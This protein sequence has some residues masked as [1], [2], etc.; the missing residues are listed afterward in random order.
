MI[1]IVYEINLFKERERKSEKVIL[2]L[3]QRQHER[4]EEMRENAGFKTPAQYII[5]LI[6]VEHEKQI[7]ESLSCMG[8]SKTED[9]DDGM[10]L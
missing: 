5:S 4:I 8:V 7:N 2:R 10:P 1:Q 3:T 9:V 6:S